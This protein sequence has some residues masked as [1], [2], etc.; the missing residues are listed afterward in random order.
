MDSFIEL[1][2]AGNLMEANAIKGALEQDG[3]LVRLLGE[4]L[5]GAAGEL[6]I[7]SQ[8][9]RLLVQRCHLD[10]AGAVLRRYQQN[11][12]PWYCSDC[13]EQ[14]DGHFEV[15]WRCGGESGN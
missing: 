13:G 6:P 1:Y 12:A 9:I 2:R 10:R 5:G 15:C 11:L 4:A 3:I 8:E 7:D 14:N